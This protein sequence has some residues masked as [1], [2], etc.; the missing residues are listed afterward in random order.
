MFLIENGNYF[1]HP[2]TRQCSDDLMCDM[3]DG[4]VFQH[5]MKD[6]FLA[7]P[8]NTGLILCTDGVPV[9][10]SAKGSIWP[11]YLAVTSLAPEKRMK[12]NNIIVAALWHGPNKPPMDVILAPVL[13]SIEVLNREGVEVCIGVTDTIKVRPKLLMAIFDLPAKACAMNT[14]QYNGKYGCFC[15]LDE[16]IMFARTRIY[17]PQCNHQLRSAANNYG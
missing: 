7:D 11:V 13:D 16:G 4:K 8:N 6:G 15:C 9:F 2:W 1:K 14:K 12:M 5:L 10:E 17:P 3:Y